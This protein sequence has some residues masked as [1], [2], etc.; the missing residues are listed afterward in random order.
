M[1]KNHGNRYSK[2]FKEEAVRLLLTSGKTAA[3]LGRELGVSTMTMCTWRRQAIA[4]GDHPQQA[5]PDGVR[6]NYAV[7][8]LEN[9][10]LKK[11]LEIA[12][13]ERDI[14][15]KSLGILSSTESPKGMP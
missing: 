7:L 6:V 1:S 14:L 11:E 2:V 13:Q 4:H 15:K 3:E 10:R 8:Q 9:A 12:R 5:K